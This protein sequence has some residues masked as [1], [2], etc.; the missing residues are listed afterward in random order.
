[1]I[2]V[3]DKLPEFTL[4]DQDDKDISSK[5]FKGKK[6]L[7]SFHPKAWTGICAS[8][9]ESLEHNLESFSKM[10][11]VPLG[12]SIDHSPTK[13]AWAKDLDIENVQMLS[14]FWP[15]G[16]YAK[17]LGLFHEG[18]GITQRA[19][20]IVDEEGTVVFVKI[21]PLGELPDINEIIEFLRK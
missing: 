15:H 9:M 11:T 18:F 7:L 3:G 16:E 20:V 6:I 4:K 13:A 21:Y 1:M 8:Q 5:E 14:D 2:Q 19:N 17:K 10:N 12:L